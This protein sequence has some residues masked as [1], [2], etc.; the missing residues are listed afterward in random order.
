VNCFT[1]SESVPEGGTLTLPGHLRPTKRAQRT[2]ESLERAAAEA[3]NALEKATRE[4]DQ[5]VREDAELEKRLAAASRTIDRLHT[6]VE[7]KFE[8]G[9]V[10]LDAA[11][12]ELLRKLS[13]DLVQSKDPKTAG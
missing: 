2:I 11:D 7:G 9:K 4:R 1:R 3:Q 12:R 5:L 13:F 10:Q 8:P 6:Q